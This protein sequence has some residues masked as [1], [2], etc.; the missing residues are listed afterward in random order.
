M[1]DVRSRWI[2]VR[3]TMYDIISGVRCTM[4]DVRLVLV[5]VLVQIDLRLEESP[6]RNIAQGLHRLSPFA[7]EGAVYTGRTLVMSPTSP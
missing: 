2:D 3:C 6:D 7:P 1:F 4:Y 5:L